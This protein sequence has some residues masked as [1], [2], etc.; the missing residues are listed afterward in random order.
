MVKSESSLR[1]P[2]SDELPG[3]DETPVDNEL[4]NL[5]PNLLGLILGSLWGNRWDWFFGV[6]MGIYLRSSWANP[7]VPLVPDGF[8]SLGVDRVKGNRLRK[9]YFVW[10]EK[11]IVPTLVLEVVSEKYGGEYHEKM[12]KYARL[13]VLYYVIYNPEF[14]A[15][16]KEQPFEVY[17]LVNKTYRLQLGEPVWMPEIGLGIGR[18]TGTY[19]G[20]TQEW[21]FWYDEQ[22]NRY[23]TPEE[24]ALAEQQQ[25][26][27]IS[28]QVAEM[29][30]TMTEM[31]QL[32]ARYRE[33]FGELP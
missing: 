31:S 20:L 3:S 18:G 10:E 15:R 12:N 6:D 9:S 8:L 2:T 25:R 16:H 24:T 26:L 1:W 32:L 22:G 23:L 19:W 4:Q 21:L 11:N 33:Q 29:S 28:Q 17:K 13:G 5:V 14:F 27:E 7:R 30:Q